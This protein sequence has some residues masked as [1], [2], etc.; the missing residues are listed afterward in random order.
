M[1]KY[2]RPNFKKSRSCLPDGN[3]FREPENSNNKGKRTKKGRTVEGTNKELTRPVT[4]Q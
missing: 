2:W 4:S 1:K 3:F